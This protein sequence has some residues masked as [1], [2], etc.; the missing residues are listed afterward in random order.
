MSCRIRLL[1][2]LSITLVPLL[3]GCL[4]RQ[5]ARDGSNLRRALNDMY[6]DQ[7]MDNLIQAHNNLPF[8]QVTYADVTVQDNDQYG[9]SL[10]ANQSLTEQLF[11]PIQRTYAT[12]FSSEGNASRSRT[13]SFVANPVTDQNDIYEAYL[14]FAHDSELFVVSDADPGCA[15][16]IVRKCHKKY[17]WVPVAA[18]PKFSNSH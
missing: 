14:K 4:S 13:M 1:L 2:I 10:G 12:M 17:Y 7:V 18:A 6:T 3:S 16:H 9:G 15:A 11:D 5:V 8:V